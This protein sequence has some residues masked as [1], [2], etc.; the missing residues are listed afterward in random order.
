MTNF[1]NFKTLILA[2]VL[3]AFALFTGCDENGGIT[4]PSG[5]TELTINTKSDKGL[6][7]PPAVV[8][9]TEAKALISQVQFEQ[10][11]NQNNQTITFTPFVIHFN[12]DGSLNEMT[13]KYIIRD[14]YTKIKFQLHKPEENE[15]PSDPEFVSG[16]QRYSFIIKGTYNGSSFI[17]KSKNSANIIINFNQTVNFDLQKMNVT[18]AFNELGWFKNG[19]SD[20]DPSNPQNAS[21]IDNNIKNSF[22]KVF[23]DNDKNGIPD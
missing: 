17:Y 8:V 9:I 16:T 10:E 13:T 12:T 3:P 7:N 4:I 5:S 11:S 19:S 15:T 20:V 18:L 21:I 6:D 14:F 2:S 23:L 1:K 22:K